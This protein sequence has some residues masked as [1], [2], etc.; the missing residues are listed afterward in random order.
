MSKFDKND[1]YVI[2]DDAPDY[3]EATRLLEG[4]Y[5]ALRFKKVGGFQP[6][7]ALGLYGD[8]DFYFQYNHGE[9]EL[10]VGVPVKGHFVPSNMYHAKMLYKT[11][12]VSPDE[13]EFEDMFAKLMDVLLEDES[14]DATVG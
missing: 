14:F 8:L 5:P 6:F 10:T 3:V 2:E 9:A 11:V 13:G 4:D 1:Q 7:S 12:D